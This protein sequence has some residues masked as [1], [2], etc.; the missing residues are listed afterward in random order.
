M[1]LDKKIKQIEIIPKHH[2]RFFEIQYKYEMPEDQNYKLLNSNMAQQILK[3]VN[4]AFKSF[5]GLVKLA[6][7]GKYDYKAIS[8]P[9]YLKKDGFHSLIIGQIRIDG[10]KFTIPYS[11]LFKKTHKK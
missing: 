10:N 5:F 3:K 2:A 11:R 9:K 8:I 6:K 1:L 4:E 7:Q